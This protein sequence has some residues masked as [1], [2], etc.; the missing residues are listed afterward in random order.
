MEP[1]CLYHAVVL[2][3]D[4]SPG[5]H[6]PVHRVRMHGAS[7]RDTHLCSLHNNSSVHLTTTYLVGAVHWTDHQCKAEWLDNLMRIRTF[8]SDN[9]TKPL[10]MTLPRRTWVRLNRLRTG[11]RRFQSCLHRWVWTLMRPVSVEQ[12]NKPSTLLSSNVK[13]INLLMDCTA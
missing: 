3:L 13:P 5:Q 9:G 7:N 8:I 4:T 1:H 6:S 10:G 11:V 2:S 12:K